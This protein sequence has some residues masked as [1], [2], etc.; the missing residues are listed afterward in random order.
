ME[1]GLVTEEQLET[2]LEEQRQSRKSLGRVLI[3]AGIVSEGDL[4]STL[5]ARIGLEFVDLLDYSIDASA[6]A[7]ISDSLA[8]RFQA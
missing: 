2:A 5:A 6:V 8:R 1:R 7:L 4:V 3:D